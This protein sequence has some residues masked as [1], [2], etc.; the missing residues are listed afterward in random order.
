M[1]VATATLT[2]TSG[3]RARLERSARLL[4]WLGNGWHLIEFTV[5]LVAG[6]LAGSIVLVGFGVDSL[7]EGLSAL[8]VVWLFTGGRG[9]SEQAEQRAQ[10]LI[11]SSYFLLALYITIESL[12]DLADSHHP[13]TSWIGIGL[14]AVAAP[15]MPLLAGAKRRIGRR[16]ESPATIREAQQNQICAYLSIALL[17]GLLA[18]ALAGWW[19][20]D[21]GAALVIA[22]LAL[23]EGIEGWRAEHVGDCC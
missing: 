18:N 21:P 14:A 17:A 1:S 4:A 15:T 16:L 10:R 19:W 22:T 12:R 2:A 11:A 6:L 13:Q 3:E 8:V 20:A 5:A 23:R 7:I 9:S